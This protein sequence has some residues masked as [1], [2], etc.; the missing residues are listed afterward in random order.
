MLTY[1]CHIEDGSTKRHIISYEV[2]MD[3][4]LFRSEDRRLLY[5][6]SIATSKYQRQRA[7]SNGTLLRGGW[8]MRIEKL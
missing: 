8:T 3:D 7:L 6:R 4:S 5:V 1:V 2:S